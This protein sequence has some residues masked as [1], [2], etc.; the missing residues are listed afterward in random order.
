MD[1]LG[2]IVAKTIIISPLIVIIILLSMLAYKLLKREKRTL[3][4]GFYFTLLLSVFFI[5]KN[6]FITSIIYI[7]PLLF[8]LTIGKKLIIKLYE[9]GDYIGPYIL[10]RYSKIYLISFIFSILACVPLLLKDQNTFVQI[11][12]VFVTVNILSSILVTLLYTLASFISL[13]L[14]LEML[15][16]DPNDNLPRFKKLNYDRFKLK[17]HCVMIINGKICQGK[18]S[19]LINPNNFLGVKPRAYKKNRNLQN[20]YDMSDVDIS[21]KYFTGMGMYEAIKNCSGRVI[22]LLR[23]A[24][25]L[26]NTLKSRNRIVFL[27]SA[28]YT[29]LVKA[30]P[31][32]PVLRRLALNIS[33]LYLIS[34]PEIESKYIFDT[35]R[36]LTPFAHH[37]FINYENNIK[38]EYWIRQNGVNCFAIDSC[39]NQNF[40]ILEKTILTSEEWLA[41]PRN[42]NVLDFRI[43]SLNVNKS[44]LVEKL[45]TN[46]NPDLSLIPI[47]IVNCKYELVKD[48]IDRI[49]KEL[50]NVNRIYIIF[51]IFEV[52]IKTF[53]IIENLTTVNIAKIKLLNVKEDELSFFISQD[54][55]ILKQFMKKF[56][57]EVFEH[58]YN[59]YYCRKELFNILNSQFSTFDIKLNEDIETLQWFYPEVTD[60]KKVNISFLDLLVYIRILRNKIKG[61]G[62]VSNLVSAATSDLLY[63]YLDII[64]K[65]INEHNLRINIDDEKI[66]LNFANF[67]IACHP[68]IL[69][70]KQRCDFLFLV[71][72]T[73][74]SAFYASYNYDI[75]YM[76]SK[77]EQIKLSDF[78]SAIEQL[79]NNIA[80]FKTILTNQTSDSEV[81]YEG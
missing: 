5:F 75:K 36:V 72:K 32:V 6:S 20:G 57:N 9:T 25:R 70:D 48:L 33:S 63:K 71:K 61:H 30:Y 54:V 65:C 46:M 22:K 13:K 29:N 4:I 18:I 78:N 16:I 53:T 7:I 81:K 80:N 19:D 37:N 66:N 77:K 55:K 28:D 15:I 40:K 3:L 52:I 41:S 39:N 2:K 8:F 79:Q 44:F 27:E 58:E 34:D 45:T 11:F 59:R 67:K 76:E 50:I 24:M 68:F 10:F 49:S 69:Y 43:S 35:L 38:S 12:G 21:M 73:N 56:P 23:T 31:N 26:A 14:F 1:Y 17:N 51:N 60:N 62:I 74:D 47:N 64:C 42:Q